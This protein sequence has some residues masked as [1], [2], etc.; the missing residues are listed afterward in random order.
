MPAEGTEAMG[1]CGAGPPHSGA[2]FTCEVIDGHVV[3]RGTIV[4]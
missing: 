2:G 3:Q 1:T 4:D